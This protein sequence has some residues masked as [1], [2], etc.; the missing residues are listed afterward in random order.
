L[1]NIMQQTHGVP[2]DQLFLLSPA[3]NAEVGD[4]G[5]VIVAF[6]LDVR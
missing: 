6:N 1:R 4:E 2:A 5:N 3:R